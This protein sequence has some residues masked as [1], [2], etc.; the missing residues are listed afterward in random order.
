MR[1][2]ISSGILEINYFHDLGPVL[3]KYGQV[4]GVV[5]SKLNEVRMLTEL[6]AS[7][8]N[9]NFAI[10]NDILLEFLRP[11]RG[12]E[13]DTEGVELDV[14]Q[15]AANSREFTVQIECRP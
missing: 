10:Q 9:Y 6:G 4:I 2:L 12:I 15:I 7:L 13:G 1:L 11:Y 8:S 5:V 14:Q 3:D